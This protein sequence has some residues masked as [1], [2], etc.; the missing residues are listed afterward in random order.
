MNDLLN[1]LNYDGPRLKV[2]KSA[3]I[4]WEGQGTMVELQALL[5]LVRRGEATLEYY[6]SWSWDQPSVL[7]IT[8][9]SAVEGR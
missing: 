6:D 1:C 8:K 2:T 3:T 5:E 9:K 7:K 4:C